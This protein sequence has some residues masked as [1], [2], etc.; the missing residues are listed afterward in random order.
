MFAWL[1]QGDAPLA[2][3][4]RALLRSLWAFEAWLSYGRPG[5]DDDNDHPP[6][7]LGYDLL[8]RTARLLPILT[9]HAARE[10]WQPILALG[11]NA[12]YA[13][14]HF[15]SAFT[16]LLGKAS[17]LMT[18][19]AHW[20]AMIEYA[21]ASADWTAG[22]HWYHGEALLCQIL[23]FGNRISLGDSPAVADLVTGL[24]DHYERW[25][26][27]HLNRDEDNVARFCSFLT[28]QA[29]AGLR[30]RALPWVASALA[31]GQRAAHWYRE[32][33]SSALISYLETLIAEEGVSLAGQPILR[34]AALGLIGMLAGKQVPRSLALQDRLVRLR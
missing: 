30:L 27:E 28:T 11:A 13:I 8:D 31:P 5:E 29:A 17:D 26:R 32:T 22:R 23:G 34:D 1:L 20:R 2:E 33:T 12:H 15:L 24:G 9:L 6:D 25:A 3:D 10:H 21:L 16:L 7:Q 4:E 19:A 18:L 14:Q